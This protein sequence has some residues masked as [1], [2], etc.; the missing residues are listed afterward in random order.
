MTGNDLELLQRL[1]STLETIGYTAAVLE[2]AGGGPL[3]ILSV[4]L[5]AD[6]QNREQQLTLAVYP[7]S[8]DLE[9]STFIQFFTQY[10][11]ELSANCLTSIER[12][13][14]TINNKLALGHFGISPCQTELHFKYVLALPLGFAMPDDNEFSSEGRS[15]IAPGCLSDVLDM[16]IFAH[17]YYAETFESLVLANE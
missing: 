1:K 10:P 5:E 4:A 6:S 14:P 7:L 12:I 3:D 2:Q 8:E 9:G 17:T 15:A 16:C 11:F 13:L